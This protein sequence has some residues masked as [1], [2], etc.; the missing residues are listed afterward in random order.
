MDIDVSEK[1]TASF[2]RVEVCKVRLQGR[3]SLRYP[4]EEQKE[5]ETPSGELGTAGRNIAHF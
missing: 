4:R 1:Y 3:K 2:F 5:N